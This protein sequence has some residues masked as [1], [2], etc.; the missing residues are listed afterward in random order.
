MW[1]CGLFVQVILWALV[2]GFQI[3]FAVRQ[4]EN[5]F[6]T[7]SLSS[8]SEEHYT[9]LE[10]PHFQSHSVRIRK[11]PSDFCDPSVVKYTGYIDTSAARH[12]F[13]YFFESRN[14]PESDDVIL[15]T[16]GGPGCSSSM[17]LFM[18]LGPCRIEDENGTK[19]NPYSWN[20]NANIFFIDQPAGT[21][22]S[23][24]EYGESVTTTE[25]AA[26]DIAAFMAIFFETF[27]Q[28]KGRPFHL[29]GE[30]YAGRY[31]PVF[32]SAIYDQNTQLVAAGLEPINLKSVMIGNGWTDV[33]RMIPSFFDMVCTPASV[34]PF[35]DISTCVRMKTVMPRCVKWLSETC[36]D[37][38]DAISCGAA[39][40]F[41]SNEFMLPF[42][43]S[44]TNPYDV[45]KPCSAEEYNSTLCYPQTR[46]IKDYLNLPSTRKELGVSPLLE[47]TTFQSCNMDLNLAFALNLDMIRGH[48]PYYLENLLDRGVRVLIY[49]GDY[50]WIANWVGNERMVDSLEW[51]G[52]ASFKK[53]ELKDWTVALVEGKDS[54]PA[55]KVKSSGLLTFLTIHGAGHMA[56]YDKPVES[57]EMV[58]RWLKGDLF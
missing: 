56:P 32:G 53:Q 29:S 10:H 49:V 52:A 51:H 42:L 5:N 31:L 2:Q 50:D 38:L 11:A 1:T 34:E 33:Y 25:E 20:E 27:S 37:R 28:F 58:N 46:H 13:F 23:Y 19:V 47:N 54:S 3:P 6:T 57:L 8:L 17:G 36:V 43:L 24:A 45:S 7:L 48:T 35:V 41:C 40:E 21:G 14:A 26:K 44:G 22:F 16:N 4:T 12:I 55:G 39:F 18:E 9:V 30:S 15:W